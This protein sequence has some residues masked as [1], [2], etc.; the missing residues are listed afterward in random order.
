MCPTLY[1]LR[2]CDEWW[3]KKIGVA[4]KKKSHRMDHN[5]EMR[6][7]LRWFACEHYRHVYA[8]PSSFV[9]VSVSGHRST[10]VCMQHAG[11]LPHMPSDGGHK[12]SRKMCESVRSAQP[13]LTPLLTPGWATPTS[14]ACCHCRAARE[15]SAREGCC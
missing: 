11:W 4:S 8:L 6:E 14:S 13:N 10:A 2:Q 1:D 3:T 12:A 7:T 15:T 9:H 5:L